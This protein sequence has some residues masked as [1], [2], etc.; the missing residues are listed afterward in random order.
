MAFNRFRTAH[1]MPENSL[2]QTH[3]PDYQGVGHN[4]PQEARQ[5]FAEAIVD[6]DCY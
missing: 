2:G 4:L 3:A 1:P 6:V 5:A